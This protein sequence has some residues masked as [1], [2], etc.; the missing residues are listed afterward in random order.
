MK[1]VTAVKSLRTAGV[2][3]YQIIDR[4]RIDKRKYLTIRIF[5]AA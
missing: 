2:R 3:Y 1:W 5:Y 4:F